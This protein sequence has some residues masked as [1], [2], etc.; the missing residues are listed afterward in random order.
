MIGWLVSHW[1]KTCITGLAEQ[2]YSVSLFFHQ[3][4]I[5]CRHSDIEREWHSLC[6]WH[7]SWNWGA[8][9]KML[10]KIENFM[11]RVIIF[12]DF[13]YYGNSIT[14]LMQH[15]WVPRDIKRHARQMA[16][17]LMLSISVNTHARLLNM[18]YFANKTAFSIFDELFKIG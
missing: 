13:N 18:Y 7:V 15:H 14:F 10:E 11:Q 1:P 6:I 5:T 4:R 2:N 16:R 3:Q 9:L 12:G 8:Q 17:W